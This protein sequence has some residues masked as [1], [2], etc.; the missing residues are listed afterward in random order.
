MRIP[1]LGLVLAAFSGA[2]AAGDLIE[3]RDD[4]SSDDDAAQAYYRL[5]FGGTRH[6]VQSVGL[7]FDNRAAQAHGAPAVFQMNFGAQGLDRLAVNGV[8]L[9]GIALAA[10]QNAPGF[11]ASLS[12]TQIIALSA[13]VLIAA[14]VAADAS[15]GNNDTSPSGTGGGP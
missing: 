15:D 11:W 6:Q 10:G 8:D 13:T 7:R 5:D 14:D 3:S 4:Y 9:H 2:A 12:W 1:V